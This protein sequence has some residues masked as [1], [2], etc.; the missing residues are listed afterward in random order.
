MT[1]T[2]QH[3]LMS[4]IDKSD[5]AILEN[6]RV[7]NATVIEWGKSVAL[8]NE[9]IQRDLLR[10]CGVKA[11]L[12]EKDVDCPTIDTANNSPGFDILVEKADGTPVRVQSKLRQVKGKTD[13]SHQTHFETTR[14]HSKKNEGSSSESGHVAYGCD[15]FDYVMN[16]ANGGMIKSYAN[17]GPVLVG[18]R[19][20]ELFVPPR[21][22][23]QVLNTDRT[24][25]L[26][27]GQTGMSN[28]N[29]M[30]NTLIVQNLTAANSTSNN[31]KIAVDTFAGV[32]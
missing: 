10:Y 24:R 9:Y 19:G 18:E 32:V 17:G 4:I 25:N 27:R 2:T 8:C 12:P 6:D 16:F 23:G 26:L 31:S 1:E 29:G 21:M 11:Y 14:R 15:E 30:I 22:G 7:Q 13:F 5:R 28:G 3:S 20:P